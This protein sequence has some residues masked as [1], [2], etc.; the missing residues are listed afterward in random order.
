MLPEFDLPTSMLNQI[1]RYFSRRKAL[2]AIGNDLVF[3]PDV[4]S[5]HRQFG[6][7]YLNFIFTSNELSDCVQADAN[8]SYARLAARI[9]AKESIMKLLKPAR[10]QLLPWQ[11]IEIRRDQ[12]GAAY[13]ELHSPARELA[14]RKNIASVAI[15]LSHEHEYASA[16]VLATID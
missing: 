4:E 10:D 16:L 8:F 9:A 3:I 6:H 1:K 2:H 14:R 7:R 5:S 12:I 11:S 15:T 13:V